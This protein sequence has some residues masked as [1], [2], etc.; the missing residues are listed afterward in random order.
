MGSDYETVGGWADEIKWV[1]SH[2]G[3]GGL[4]GG[5]QDGQVVGGDDL[6]PVALIAEQACWGL[7]M[8]LVVGANVFEAAEKSVAVAGD[9]AVAGFSGKGSAFDV[10]GS[11]PE[12]S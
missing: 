4:G 8:N 2:Q 9:A 11:P 5:S 7:H 10:A 6:C 1:A 12:H 3:E